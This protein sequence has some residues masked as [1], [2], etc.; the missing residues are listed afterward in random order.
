MQRAQTIIHYWY[1]SQHAHYLQ[2]H[3]PILLTLF[4]KRNIM[5]LYHVHLHLHSFIHCQ[6]QKK[7]SF[8]LQSRYFCL[9]SLGDFLARRLFFAPLTQLLL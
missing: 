9:N 7:K 3:F 6:K 2:T 4:K 8:L 1:Y 5:Y